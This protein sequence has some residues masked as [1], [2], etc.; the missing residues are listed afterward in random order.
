M[1]SRDQADST[2]VVAP[3]CGSTGSRQGAY[4]GRWL[5]A[6][7]LVLYAASSLLTAGCS[8]AFVDIDSPAPAKSGGAVSSVMTMSGSAVKG[9]FAV[10]SPV[11]A[12]QVTDGALGPGLGMIG[13]DGH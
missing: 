1:L 12:F 13:H 7:L 2:G 4:V 3:G 5:H 9:P 6:V 11:A 10:D 8:P